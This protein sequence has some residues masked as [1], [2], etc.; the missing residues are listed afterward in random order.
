VTPPIDID[1]AMRDYT[2][3]TEDQPQGFADRL[4]RMSIGGKLLLGLIPLVLIIAIVIAILTFGSSGNTVATQSALPPKITNVK[5]NVAGESKIVVSADTDLP[6]GAPVVVALKENGQ[7]FAWFNPQTANVRANDGKIQ[8]T[9]EK[10]KDAPAPKLGQEYLVV[11]TTQSGD[12]VISSEPAALDVPGPLRDKFFQLVV[13]APTSEPTA[14]P[15][16]APTTPPATEP[17][18]PEPTSTPAI[19]LTASVFN[20][21]NIRPQP[22]I[23]A[24][25]CP[26]LHAG[27]IVQLL[28]KTADSRWYR[29][30][31][32]EGT[33]W[34]SVTLLR[35]DAEVA[36]QVLVEGQQ[37]PPL[38]G[39]GGTPTAA[40]SGLTAAVRNGGNVRERP[41]SGRPLDQVNAGETVQ[42]IEKTAD[43]AW[44]KITNIRG[45]SGWVSA[46]LLTIDQATAKQVPI[47]K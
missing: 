2:I 30:V 4:R 8:A 27:Q 32:P 42:L 43:G 12:Q 9:L 34:V 17:P 19:S 10:L 20:G 16:A 13:S 44:Y 28:E 5:A 23:Q 1:S 47:A 3:E 40:P 45:V 38:P 31:A 18:P 25:T 6:N 26:Q 33:G 24:C 35:I 36:K 41:V 21:G 39:S 22:K 29:V 7:D 37:T 14:A 46:S 15:R 11:L